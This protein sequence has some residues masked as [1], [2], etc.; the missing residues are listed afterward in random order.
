MS[1]PPSPTQISGSR[2]PQSLALAMRHDKA[3]HQRG[4]PS[5]AITTDAQRPLAA[6]DTD[7]RDEMDQDEDFDETP[8]LIQEGPDNQ[9]AE[10]WEK[11][12]CGG[13][14]RDRIEAL[15]CKSE[16]AAVLFARGFAP[17]ARRVD[18]AIYD[19]FDEHD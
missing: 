6:T 8:D 2:G 14:G 19:E 15:F 11:L 17:I 13:H 16:Y 1:Q 9:G 12:F 5:A 7:M 3:P 4:Q 18:Q 10:A